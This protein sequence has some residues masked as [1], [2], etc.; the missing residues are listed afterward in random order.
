MAGGMAAAHAVFVLRDTFITGLSGIYLLE[1]FALSD[2]DFG[3]IYMGCMLASA[4]TLP[5]LGQFI[6][7]HSGAR[8]ILLAIYLLRL[9]GQGMMSHVALTEA[10]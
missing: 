7:R 4:A 8:V 10:R 9:F 2:G 5:W 6:D 3:L 1:E